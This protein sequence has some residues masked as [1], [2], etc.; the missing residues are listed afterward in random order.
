MKKY[1]LFLVILLAYLLPAFAE[2]ITFSSD[3]MT[4]KFAAGQEQ[5]WL[6]GN[7]HVRQG[8]MTI[9]AKTIILYGANYEVAVC[10]GDVRIVEREHNAVITGDY[11]R[12]QK[13]PKYSK[14]TR[15]PFLDLRDEE[16]QIRAEMMEKYWDEG[17][18]IATGNV[19]ITKKDLTAVNERAV[20]DENEHTITLEG[21]PRVQI[22][23]DMYFSERIVLTTTNDHILLQNN[24]QI[25]LYPD[26]SASL[27]GL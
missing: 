23:S 22:G 11:V 16:I 4:F 1:T 3:Q 21:A 20:Y 14:V 27:L 13:A 19:I 12:H 7:A 6:T 25:I 2:V 9:T 10:E 17:R 15:N 5:T 24:V 26:N 18:N 8:G